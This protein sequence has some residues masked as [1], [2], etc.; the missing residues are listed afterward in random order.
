MRM[1]MHMY[2]CACM[3][4]MGRCLSGGAESEMDTR[5]AAFARNGA[6]YARH[7]CPLSRANRLFP[8]AG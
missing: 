8:P 7:V 1:W 3:H 2:V 5:L 4:E 6:R